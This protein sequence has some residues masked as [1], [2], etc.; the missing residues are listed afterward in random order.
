MRSDRSPTG[1]DSIGWVWKF[2]SKLNRDSSHETFLPVWNLQGTFIFSLILVEV[3]LDWASTVWHLSYSLGLTLFFNC[4]L[5]D[6]VGFILNRQRSEWRRLGREFGIGV[7]CRESG[8]WFRDRGLGNPTTFGDSKGFWRDIRLLVNRWWLGVLWLIT[9]L[10][11]GGCGS[12]VSCDGFSVTGGCGI[13]GGWGT[14]NSSVTW[15]S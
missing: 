15:S 9:S 2:L 11:A 3:L 13:I 7:A 10:G 12:S 14:N 8:L 4:G 5:F 1:N 6:K